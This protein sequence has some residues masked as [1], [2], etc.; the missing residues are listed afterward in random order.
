LRSVFALQIKVLRGAAPVR[1]AFHAFSGDEA[2][3][4]L[5]LLGKAMRFFARCSY[6]LRHL[7]S[8]VSTR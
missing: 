3:A 2:Q 5:W 4:G 6:D 8:P 1:V 7:I